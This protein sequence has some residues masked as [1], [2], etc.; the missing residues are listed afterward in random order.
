M[1]YQELLDKGQWT[2][3][4]TFTVTVFSE[5][6]SDTV[7]FHILVNQY[8]EDRKITEVAC[9]ALNDF[10]NLKKE[11]LDWIKEGLYANAQESFKSTTWNC[12]EYKDNQTE[13]EANLEYFKIYNKEDAYRHSKISTIFTDNEELESYCFVCFLS[14]WENEHEHIFVFA[15]GEKDHIE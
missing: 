14:S 4:A 6:L 8:S 11:N 3:N 12:V 5:L 15:N 7:E 13:Y 10:L 2:D 1:T 9:Q